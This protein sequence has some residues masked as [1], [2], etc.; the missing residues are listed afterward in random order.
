MAPFGAILVCVSPHTAKLSAFSHM[1]A[2]R[3]T[4]SSTIY[5]VN[6]RSKLLQSMRNQPQGWRVEQLLS[7]AAYFGI[8][9]R[10]HGS[11]HHVFSYPGIDGGLCVP[12]HRPIKPVYIR[13]FLCL[14]DSVMEMNQ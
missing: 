14:L 7:I 9:C 4:I 6:Q 12:A 1:A 3:S 11:S 2:N 5:R 8:T 10:N 13:Q